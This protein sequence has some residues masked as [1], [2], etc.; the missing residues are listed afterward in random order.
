MM[1]AVRRIGAAVM[2][3]MSAA[4]TA[5]GCG[6][7]MSETPAAAATPRPP[8]A[9]TTASASTTALAPG[10]AR[11]TPPLA[12]APE[13]TTDRQ[14]FAAMGKEGTLVPGEEKVL[15]ERQGAGTINH[16]WFGGKWPGWGETRIRV[17]VDGEPEPTIDMA[18]LLGH[19]IGWDDGGSTPEPW[20]IPRFGRTGDPG[21]V[22]NTYAIPFGQG[23]KVTASLAP[24]VTHPQT[25][26]WTVRGATG[27]RV[28][29]GDIE[30]PASAR[31]RLQRRENVTLSPLEMVTLL[32]TDRHGLLYGVTMTAES[33]NFDYLEAGLRAFPGDTTEP[34][35]LSSGTNDY[36]LGTNGF[37][38]GL[39]RL[40][41][42]GVTHLGPDKPGS[43]HRFA[44]YRL[45]DEDP[46]PFTNGLRLLW[47]NGEERNGYR[48]GDPKP[49]TITTYVWTYEWE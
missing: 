43:R 31:L 23:V 45:H 20:G 38:S 2:V 41:I 9:I 40:P 16:M 39:Y 26:W 14:P 37:R 25:F 33:G 11:E 49:T 46:L 32:D 3:A 7:I 8:V 28:R 30:L 10:L 12:P 1:R 13:A 36:F 34:V 22:Y 15:F 4:L 18:L 27:L 44:A 24:E 21:G 17:Y 42:A 48:F 29:I 19:G 6:Q 35:W 5:T 47:R